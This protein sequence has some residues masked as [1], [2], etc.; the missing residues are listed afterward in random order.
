[1][2]TVVGQYLT[3]LASHFGAQ[4]SHETAE[5]L[6]LRDEH[7]AI[8]GAHGAGNSPTLDNEC[9]SVFGGIGGASGDHM[10]KM[11][12]SH[13]RAATYFF[14]E[15][16][17]DAFGA[18]RACLIAFRTAFA[19][20]RNTNWGLRPL[21][22]LCRDLRL[23]GARADVETGSGKAKYLE[24]AMEEIT[25]CFRAIANDRPEDSSKS[26]RLGMM[27]LANHMLCIGFQLNNFA[28]LK[29]IK[30]GMEG[31]GTPRDAFALAHRVT[32]AY[33]MGR[34]ALFDADYSGAK[35]HLDMALKHCRRDSKRNKRLILTYLIPVNLISGRLPSHKLMAKYD[36]L[37][38]EPIVEALRSG[39][40]GNLRRGLQQHGE[41]FVQWGILLILEK[42]QMLAY[43]T[44]FKRVHA[45]LAKNKMNLS[46]FLSAMRF[47][48]DVKADTDEVECILA[49]LIAQRYVKGYIAHSHKMLVVSPKEPFPP[50]PF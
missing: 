19:A 15:R 38:F 34:K 47:A 26:K 11:A 5:L 42:L 35:E 10:A 48:G 28:F 39:N 33:Y 29:P 21:D 22:V 18:Q 44:L 20:Q 13:V 14:T 50:L 41:F 32:Y 24:D 31:A 43:R 8:L 37:Q 4:Y 30:R 45:I 49:N 46:F 23:L 40:V 1:M 17:S 6:S 3:Q 16:T 7:C 25:N 12:A 36:L 9:A 27:L 2:A